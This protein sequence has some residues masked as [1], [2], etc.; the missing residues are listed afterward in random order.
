MDERHKRL[1][2]FVQPSLR[3][4]AASA[5]VEGDVRA[6]LECGNPEKSGLAMVG[7]GGSDLR[8]LGLYEEALLEAWLY[9]PV[10]HG[11]FPCDLF[12]VLF[13][14]A[15]ADRMRAAGDPLPGPG[16]F[17]IYRGVAGRGP[18][19]RVF[20]ASVGV[21]RVRARTPKAINQEF[22]SPLGTSVCRFPRGVGAITERLASVGRGSRRGGE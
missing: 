21:Q 5:L 13:E 9:P 16:P 19:R 6:W 22:R 8:A 10:N 3:E 14:A 1:L 2:E 20:F 11:K 12:K 15:D 17:T 18:A 4:E 7:V